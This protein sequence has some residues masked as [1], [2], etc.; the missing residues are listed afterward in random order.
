[1]VG[2]RRTGGG[3]FGRDN[4]G[5]AAGHEGKGGTAAG[6]VWR[7]KRRH[8]WEGGEGSMA[9]NSKASSVD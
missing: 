7:E 9:K 8:E 3:D 6:L 2:V 1:M 4:G 5:A